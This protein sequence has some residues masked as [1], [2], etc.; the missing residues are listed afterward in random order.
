VRIASLLQSKGTFVA[1]IGPSQTLEQVLAVLAEHGVG[2]LVVSEDGEHITG[3][4]SERD[5][6]RAL[7]RRGVEVLTEP[8]SAV[9]TA[10]VRTCAP[11]ETIEA[12]MALMTEQ[13]IRHVPV[14]EEDKLAGIVS[15]GDL[16]KERM[17]QLER[18]NSAI[19]EYIQTGR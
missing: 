3:I 12:L 10:E 15:I 19:V 4:V 6:V 5:V 1:T 18:E 13:R 7:H 2:A 11:G 14:V 8:V 17:G 16:V 9:M